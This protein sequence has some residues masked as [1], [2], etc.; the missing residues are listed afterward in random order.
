MSRHKLLSL[1][2]HSALAAT[3]APGLLF[4]APAV[5][6][7]WDPESGLGGHRVVVR[8]EAAAVQPPP[9][10]ARVT[11]DWRRRDADPEKKNVLVFDAATGRRVVKV[12]PVRLGREAAEFLFEPP[13]VPG[14]YFFYYLP[15]KSEGRRNYPNVRY[16]PP[17]WSADPALAA[18]AD[19]LRSSDAGAA[20]RAAADLL[21][22]EAVAFESADDFGAFT[23]MERIATAAE[24]RA[25]LAA[26]PG[27]PY[28]LFP[29]DRALPIRMTG[30]L[31]K[32]WVEAGPLGA[33]RGR[34]A[35]G[36]YFT[37][38]VGLWA[39]RQAIAD[40]EVRFSDLVRTPATADDGSPVAPSVI[41]GRDLTCF[42]KGGVGW[43]GAPFVKAVPVDEGRVQALW[44]G[45][46][47]PPGI[48]SG[49]F[50]GTVTV[51]PKGMPATAL[52]V[53]LTV[54]DETLADSG[55]GDPSRLT[56]LRWLDSTLAQDDGIVPPFTALTVDRFTV[57]CL[58]RAL[59]IGRDGFPSRIRSYFAPEMTRLQAKPVD[60]TA[61]PIRLRVL[62]ED[63]R[64]HAWKPSLTGPR[65]SR[66]GPGAV[67]WEADNCNGDFVLRIE[68]RMEF[69][70]FVA[71]KV[72][73]TARRD[74]A[75]SDI[76]LEVPW[77]EASAAYMMGLGFPGGRR[78]ASFDWAWDQKKNQD[79]L[80][81]GT[82]NAGMQVGLRAENYSRPLNTNFYLSKPLQM[83]PSWW[84]EG[85]GT[86]TVRS[87]G[88]GGRGGFRP[89]T[90]VLAAASGPRRLRVGETLH[91][92]FTLLI[93][94]FKPLDP[95]AHFRQRYYHAFEPLDKV[96]AAGANVVNVHHATA[97][98]PYINYPFLRVPEMKAY[99]DDAH[100]RGF[101]VKIYDTVRELSNRA[102]EL[103]ALR[104]LGH[105]IFSPGPGG[106]YAWLQEHLGGDYI[107]A[108]FVPDLKDA[109]IINSGL[110]RWHNYYVEGLDWLA[111]NVGIDGLYLDDVA[112]DRTTMK[113]VRKVLA[114][115]RPGALIDLHSANQ[116]NVRDGFASSANLY[117]E[118][119]PY[120]DRLWFGEYFDYNGSGP[121]YWLV[122]LSGLPFGLMG[123]MLQ[124]GGNP[125][126]GMVFGM[127][128]RLPWAG[129]PRPLWKVWD[130][131]GITKSEMA[132][133]WTASNPVRTGTPDVLATCYV[134]KGDGKGGRPSALVAL[135]SWAKAPVD[136][137]LA[138][139]WKKLGLDPK[140]ASLR[141]P[142]ID[143]F[144]EGGEFEPGDPIRI[145]P[146]K[147]LLLILR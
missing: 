55:D 85:R 17:A 114:R 34:A 61:G 1:L 22:A 24:T 126:R 88:S 112:F 54:T 23:P 137:R 139:D 105:E 140:K 99:V 129:D 45:V 32:R 59:T 76:R 48:R 56:R 6:A 143:K 62:D 84:N 81:I 63:G 144:Q 46:P 100:R 108:W 80:W 31:P 95:A 49:K 65:L 16:D 120:L 107:A 7:D 40:L 94:P 146:G 15:Y 119:F 131:F 124:D 82:V 47:V 122:E 68:A 92:D 127:T 147:G 141:A 97:V 106:G 13:T 98:N 28:L 109:A 72:S 14:D 11:I 73:L 116:Y 18:R 90:V 123:E 128:A 64:E 74:V 42:N 66:R 69:D 113:R 44:C 38:Q 36:E 58:G 86:V 87:G 70:G 101:K 83:P 12:L 111:R 50:R 30:D 35:R 78:P 52:A 53:E 29:E 132:G 96:A 5:A 57:G 37:F 135:A 117:L 145:E 26:H 43:D 89:G 104:S 110:S 134:R 41:P 51:A 8:V 118:H 75:V 25:L 3:L 67:V 77:R 103:F 19:A 39:A 21:R 93:T 138:V 115:N 142:A 9:R 33:I 20:A 79:A 121:D 4:P 10:I 136:V 130:E 27:S 2:R 71:S 91:F 125:W 60:I 133:W 102:P